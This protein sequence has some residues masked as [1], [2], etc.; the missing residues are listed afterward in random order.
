MVNI[1]LQVTTPYLTYAEYARASGLPYNTVKKM[2]Y[3]GRLPTRP[4]NDPRSK[5]LINVQALVIEAA[6]LRLADQKALIEDA[7]QVS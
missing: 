1:T 6:E 5:P 7:N 2:V 3:E 4:K